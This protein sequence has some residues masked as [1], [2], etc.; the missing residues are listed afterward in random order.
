MGHWKLQ[1]SDVFSFDEGW[2]W[3]T[4]PPRVAPGP[5]GSGGEPRCIFVTTLAYV[6]TIVVDIWDSGA[7]NMKCHERHTEGRTDVKIE[8]VM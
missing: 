5:Q 8:I 7:I 4:E 1:D 3:P 6:T 2:G